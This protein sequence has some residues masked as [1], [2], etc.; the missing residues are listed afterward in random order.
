MER[1]EIEAFLTL[2]EELHFRR[3]SERLGLAQGRVSQTIKK[4]ERRFGVALFERTSRHV[5]LTPAGRQLRDDLLPVQEQLRRAVDRV[6]AAGRGVTEVLHVGYSSPMVAELLLKAAD[7]FR[8]RCPGCEVE[9]HEVQLFESFGPIRSGR[10][11]LQVSEGPVDEPDLTLGPVLFSERRMLMVPAGHAFAR[12]ASVSLE[13]LAE[14]TLVAVEGDQPPYWVDRHYPRHTPG[15]RPIARI[16]TTYWTEVLNLVGRGKGVSPAC[17]G[18]SR[19]YARQDVA[20][21]PFSDAEPIEYG[22][23]WPTGTENART[24]AFTDTVREVAGVTE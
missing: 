11:H 10:L 9:I 3:T 19:Y 22:A 21:V 24:R 4:L 12:R 13:D 6:K 17:E 1:H 5:A 14:T 23:F 20:W 8:G 2:A 7:V 15:G 16:S 18:A